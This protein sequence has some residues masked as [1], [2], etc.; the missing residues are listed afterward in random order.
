M[1]QC[2]PSEEFT[3]GPRA[4]K[5]ALISNNPI[6]KDIYN[7]TF[8]NTE[9]HFL[10]E[11]YNQ[12]HTLF[13]PVLIRTAFDWFLSCPEAPEDFESFYKAKEERKVRLSKKNIYLQ[14][15]G[16]DE[17]IPWDSLNFLLGSLKTYLEAFF[18]GTRVKIL[19]ALPASSIQTCTRCPSNTK[20][21]QLHTD[22]ILL[23][24]KKIKPTGAC[25]V[26]GLLLHDIYPSDHWN[27]TFGKSFPQ[28][29]VSVCS[30][31]RI[32]TDF[33][34]SAI[35]ASV[36]TAENQMANENDVTTSGWSHS[37]SFS[38]NEM[39]QCCKITCHEVCH[40]YQLGNCRWL[41]CAMQG[42][43]SK[44]D[45]FLR[46]LH[47]C[48]IC[49]RKL[50]NLLG[51]KL[52]ERYQK[53]QSWASGVLS[54]TTNKTALNRSASK[55]PISSQS[56]SGVSCENDLESPSPDRC[57]QG[58]LFVSQEECE[59]IAEESRESTVTALTPT[60]VDAFEEYQAWLEACIAMLG[61]DVSTEEL[62]KLDDAADAMAAYDI[63][64]LRPHMVQKTPPTQRENQ[65]LRRFL[66]KKIHSF[67]KIIN[68]KNLHWTDRLSLD[69]ISEEN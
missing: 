30:F 42:V 28:H 14:P 65:G 56:D 36:S 13:K 66:E 25:F 47:L 4:L 7:N 49:L 63:S 31:S 23:H 48:P 21:L 12:Q 68:T 39:M 67:C 51:F 44:E 59:P 38:I 3:F 17:T 43:T 35:T 19:S 2:R 29:D 52:I 41:S 11:A 5:E 46:P 9:K 34:Q 26:V 45:L 27:Y 61:R 69:T 16:V 57:S 20:K 62:C 54:F 10:S 1:L 50:H 64:T 8:T 58:L 24:L 55:D 6:L 32:L 15:I 33:S 53:L 22:G 40:L 37:P 18:P 60:S